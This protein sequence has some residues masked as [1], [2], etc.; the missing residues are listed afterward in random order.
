MSLSPFSDDF[1]HEG[2]RAKLQTPSATLVIEFP[3]TGKK[4]REISLV[5]QGRMVKKII[6]L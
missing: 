2:L 6:G 3:F 5:G 1:T 4:Y